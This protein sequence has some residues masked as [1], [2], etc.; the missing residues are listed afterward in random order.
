MTGSA[1]PDGLV[2]GAFRRLTR[3]VPAFTRPGPSG[4]RLPATAAVTAAALAAPADFAAAWRTVK[5]TPGAELD[6]PLPPS[7]PSASLRADPGPVGTPGPVGLPLP[8]GDQASDLA[9]SV[10]AGLDPTG[11]VR[12]MVDA[13]VL[14]LAP[15]RDHDVPPRARLDPAFSTPMSARLLALSV[16]YL[17]PGIG[18]VPDNTLGLLEVNWAFVEAFLAGLN[19]ELGRE[20]LWREFPATPGATWARH[21]WDSGPGGP[22]DIQPI[23][24][25]AGDVALGGHQP[26]ALPAADLVLLCKGALPRRYPDLRVY[27][28]EADWADDGTRIEKD[29][30]Q[31]AA[32]V[33]AASLARDTVVWGFELSEA[34]ARGSTDP[35]AGRPG[36]FFVLEQHPG[37]ARFG[38]DA[39][40]AAARGKAPRNWANLS[41]SHLAPEGDDPL[42]AFADPSGPSWL[43][44][45]VERP[46]NGGPDGRDAWGDDAAAM[47]R[48][49]L[50]RPVRMLVH[51]DAMLPPAP[52]PPPGWQPPDI[53]P[54][55]PTLPGPGGPKGPEAP[56]PGGPKEPR[57]PGGPKEPRTPGGP[58]EP[59]TPGGPKEPRTPGGPKGPGRG[60]PGGR[61]GPKRGEGGDPGG[62]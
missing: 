36:W 57:T 22:A 55:G 6:G 56:G 62:R 53:D 46:G 40:R 48:I 54:K 28:V 27:A 19:H 11:T 33:L 15:D 61:Q 51:A 32:P 7:P 34:E 44:D 60:R 9:R 20:F 47:A 52:H 26:A 13:R 35:D 16:E 2:S 49:T 4:V 29:G 31:V 21:F 3:T 12:A 38:L 17:V 14:G 24:R 45:G 43:A 23:G 37:A 10:R 42:P 41:W 58:K 25:W 39:P 5:V 30:G 18:A 8:G 50:Q 1:L 59:R